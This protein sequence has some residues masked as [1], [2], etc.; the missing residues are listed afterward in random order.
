MMKVFAEPS[1]SRQTLATS[2]AGRTRAGRANGQS[3][4][5]EARAV[6]MMSPGQVR[7]SMNRLNQQTAGRT[8]R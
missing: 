8:G 6:S 1:T 7:M 3:A 5:E 4:A 2:R